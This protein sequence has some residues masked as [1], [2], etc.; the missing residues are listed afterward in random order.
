MS[1]T[2]ATYR[3][4]CGW[5]ARRK[6]EFNMVTCSDC[7]R[8]AFEA[9]P[10]PGRPPAPPELARVELRVRPLSVSIAALGEEQAREIGRTAIDRAAKRWRRTAPRK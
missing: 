1:T 6:A 3:C 4:V 8:V 2:R 5:S 7:G 10:S 9:D